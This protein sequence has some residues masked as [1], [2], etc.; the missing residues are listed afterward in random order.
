LT[1]TELSTLGEVSASKAGGHSLTVVLT[2]AAQSRY[3]RV[4]VE[5]PNKRSHFF[6][7]FR[8]QAEAEKWIAEHRWLTERRTNI[9]IAG[10]DDLEAHEPTK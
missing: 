6:G 1:A 7:K 9:I 5:W 4:K 3:W 2:A 10:A 8:S